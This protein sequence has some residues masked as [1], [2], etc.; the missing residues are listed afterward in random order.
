MQALE[1]EIQAAKT[2]ENVEDP[3]ASMAWRMLSAPLRS[4]ERRNTSWPLARKP[5]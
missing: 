5:G 1:E 3:S 4:R 2:I